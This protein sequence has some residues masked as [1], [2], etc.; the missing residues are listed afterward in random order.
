[1][2]LFLAGDVTTESNG[3]REGKRITAAR[4]AKNIGFRCTMIHRHSAHLHTSSR[5][6]VGPLIMEDERPSLT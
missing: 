2:R 6:P 5:Q 3:T 4:V 1:M